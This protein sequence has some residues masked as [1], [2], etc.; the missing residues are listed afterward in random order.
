[1]AYKKGKRTLKKLATA[2]DKFTLLVDEVLKKFDIGVFESSRTTKRQI[3]LF[4]NKRSQI[5]GIKRKS[6][7]QITKRNPKS[8]AIDCFPY[9][10]GL[11]TFNGSIK[12]QLLFYEMYWHFHRASLKLKIP[13]RWGGLWSFKDKPHI[14]LV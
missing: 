1:M 11:N 4:K 6:K 13:I 10:K 12:S 9:V 14:E 7:H 3:Q 2:D 5:D 8:K